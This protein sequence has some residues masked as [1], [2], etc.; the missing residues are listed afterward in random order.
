MLIKIFHTF[1]LVNIT[2]SDYG[3]SILQTTTDLCELTPVL[4]TPERESRVG[5]ARRRTQT[6]DNLCPS[7][8]QSSPSYFPPAP[9]SAQTGGSPSTA[10]GQ[11]L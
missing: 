5:E 3:L 10:P 4:M 7:P 8:A 6:E 2:N 1:S 11:S 9:D